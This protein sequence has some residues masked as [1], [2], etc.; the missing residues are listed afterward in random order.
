ML[1]KRQAWKCNRFLW[2]KTGNPED[3]IDTC[4]FKD[5]VGPGLEFVCCTAFDRG[6]PQSKR[7]Q[8]LG[9]ISCQREG[10]EP[11]P[12]R[13]ACWAP[14]GP[15]RVRWRLQSSCNRGP[16]SEL[17]VCRLQF[18][19]GARQRLLRPNFLQKACLSFGELQKCGAFVRRS[20]QVN[21]D[22]CARIN[23]ILW[24]GVLFA[25]YSHDYA[26]S[27]VLNSFRALRKVDT[28]GWTILRPRG[29][30][31]RDCTATWSEWSEKLKQ[32][33]YSFNKVTYLQ[34]DMQH[35]KVKNRFSLQI[36][37]DI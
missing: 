23:T 30:G 15:K 8:G 9:R 28:R 34:I 19:L 24:R 14:R 16:G 25:R 4:L 22:R 1:G 17:G 10:V 20:D 21:S 31:N 26:R 5:H 33:A 29:T 18:L 32:K 12:Q 6:N 13:A 36:C 11:P 27:I 7:L 37:R 2:F 3:V 35:H